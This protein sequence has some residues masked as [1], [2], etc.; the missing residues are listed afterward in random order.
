MR[1]LV[2]RERYYSRIVYIEVPT[3]DALEAAA[4][5]ILR[6]REEDCIWNIPTTAVPP[7]P[8]LDPKQFTANSPTQKAISKLWDE[9]YDAV[10]RNKEETAIREMRRRAIEEG[11]GQIAWEVLQAC[12]NRDG[13]LYDLEE[14]V[15]SYPS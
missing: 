3:Q 5:S 13:W 2:L 11:N 8:E 12:K 10:R 15:T 4:L 9:Y 14:T 6:G 1:L 7:Q